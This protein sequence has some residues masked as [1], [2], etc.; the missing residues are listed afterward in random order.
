MTGQTVWRT[1]RLSQAQMQ[2]TPRIESGGMN[3]VLADLYHA[4]VQCSFLGG[5][6]GRTIRAQ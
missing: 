5:K 2:T 1:G 6:I 4:L 3:A